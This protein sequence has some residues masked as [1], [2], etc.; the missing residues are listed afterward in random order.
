MFES[1][2]IHH[3][4]FVSRQLSY[5]LQDHELEPALAKLSEAAPAHY[6]DDIERLRAVLSSSTP[7]RPELGATPYQTMTDLLPFVGAQRA[8][9]FRHFVDYIE[10][11]RATF[12]TYWAGVLGLMWY[13]LATSAVALVV[14]INFSLYVMPGFTGVFEGF[15]ERLP[16]LTAAVFGVSGSGIL[17]L[18][19]FLVL[20]IASFALFAFMFR[21][22]IQRLTPL[23]SVP[24]WTPL[25][26]PLARTYNLG[27]F[28]NFVRILRACDVEPVR[29]VSAATRVTNQGHDLTY[30][31][32]RDS[33]RFDGVN[34]LGELAVA[35][36]VDNFD[37]ELEHQCDQHISELVSALV[38]LRDRVS[39]VLKIA[40]FVFVGTLVV[41]M[42][43]PIFRLGTVI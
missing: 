8:T 13:L 26:G 30:N 20:M 10:Q 38:R 41:A 22:S 11:S 40:L 2:S 5:L 27:L 12:Q 36:R 15:G 37:K 3:L 17:G 42:Y 23:P 35:A 14:M 32:L 19:A 21:R 16:R 24:Q 7:L 31:A 6:A 28:M 18:L 43:L 39:I 33:N 1:R 34:T 29:A 4:A 25:L 9:F